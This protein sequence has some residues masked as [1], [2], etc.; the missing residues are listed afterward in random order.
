M[1]DQ[2]IPQKIWDSK[3]NPLF[4][5]LKLDSDQIT[6]LIIELLDQGLDMSHYFEITDAIKDLEIDLLNEKD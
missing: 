4:D 6:E 1:S 2:K 3:I 5:E